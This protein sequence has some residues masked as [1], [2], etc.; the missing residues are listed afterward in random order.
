MTQD[1]SMNQIQEA[2]GQ[3]LKI[4]SQKEE[5]ERMVNDRRGIR[6]K[7]EQTEKFVSDQDL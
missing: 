5:L 3:G 6:K 1:K 2:L 7:L 4:G